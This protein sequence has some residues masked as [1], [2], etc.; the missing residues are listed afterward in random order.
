MSV[1]RGCALSDLGRLAA[2]RGIISGLVMS[3]PPRLP[4]SPEVAA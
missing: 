4:L 2:E 1:K 3:P